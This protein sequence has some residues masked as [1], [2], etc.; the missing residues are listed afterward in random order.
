MSGYQ[1]VSG[2]LAVLNLP[3]DQRLHVQ[4][5]TYFYASTLARLRRDILANRSGIVTFELTAPINA[6]LIHVAMDRRSTWVLGFRPDRAN[7]WWVFDEKKGR[8]LPVLPG[9]PSR[10]MGLKG[11]Y[12]ELGLPASAGP[13]PDS[14][15]PSNIND[16]LSNAS[17]STRINMRPERLLDLLAGF[18]G[19]PDPEFSRAILLLLFLVAEALRFDNVL[20]ECVRY[21]M[22]FPPH[23]YSIRP[24]FLEPTIHAWATSAPG[25]PNVLVPWLA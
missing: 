15:D 18:Q 7:F 21:F 3:G 16:D 1:Q 23:G 19:G 25:H 17:G 12:T 10:S 14:T 5:S 24:G 4:L 9:G 20:R 2:N 11:S 6:P 13:I 8:P 22:S